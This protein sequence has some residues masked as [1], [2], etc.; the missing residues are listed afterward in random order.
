[1]SR[2]ILSLLV[3]TVIATMAC[4]VLAATKYSVG[5]CVPKAVNFSTIGAAVGGV[6]SGA[7]IQVCPGVYPEQVTITRPLTLQG[8]PY[9]NMGRP[10]IIISPNAILTPNVNS[11][12]GQSFYAQVLVQNVVPAGPVNITGI[13][14]DGS[15]GN[16]GCSSAY[17]LAGIFYASGTSGTVNA[18]TARNQQSSN[19]GDGIWA[20]NGAGPNQSITIENSSIHDFDSNGIVAAS[21]QIPS[22]L[23]AT[24][25]G[26]FLTGLTGG[27]G[28]GIQASYI[29]GAVA[30]NVLTNLSLG[31]AS[32]AKGGPIAVTTNLVADQPAGTIA[33]LPLDSTTASS[34]LVANA[35][36]AFYLGNAGPTI[37]SNTVMNVNVAVTFNCT[38]ASS[39]TK[40]VVNDAQ[41]GFS[42][43]HGTV[44]GN[45]IYNLDTIQSGSCP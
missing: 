17:G 20:E 26:N 2:I 14:I 36:T 1:M 18:V 34:N 8:V 39:A 37:K 33:F 15:R 6:P 10:V 29:N 43:A 11:I 21:N 30:D 23:A 22:T 31:V 28:T 25:R 32:D 9:N 42:L 44:V 38:S 41:T 27:Q 24:L 12:F 4:P 35:F 16:G 7:T 40:N 19:C 3:I 13:T 45:A 5:G